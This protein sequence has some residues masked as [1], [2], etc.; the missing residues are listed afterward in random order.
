[1]KQK[2]TNIGQDAVTIIS[3]GVV[4][5]GKISS[6]GNVRIDGH[7]KGNVNA[8]GNVT[9]GAQG[10]IEGEINAQ[11]IMLG[12]K[13]SGSV[14]ASEK[15]LLESTSSLKG[16]IITKI[17]VIEEGALFEGTSNMGSREQADKGTLFS[18][19]TNEKKS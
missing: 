9:I 10:E 8:K 15:V 5:E 6:N 12:G 11:I 13:I 17:L 3:A 7:V 14:I 1:M 18:E 19:N 16:D 2:N 4:L